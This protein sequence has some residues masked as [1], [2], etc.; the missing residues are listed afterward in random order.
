MDQADEQLLSLL[1]TD[2]DY[3]FRNIHMSWLPGE[4]ALTTHPRPCYPLH[5]R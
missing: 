2:L 5:I 4:P 1:A 3:H